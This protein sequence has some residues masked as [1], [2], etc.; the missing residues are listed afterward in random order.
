ME[1]LDLRIGIVA[2]LVFTGGMFAILRREGRHHLRLADEN[3]AAFADRIAGNSRD[4]AAL[5]EELG[6]L[7]SR[8]RYFEVKD[9]EDEE[10]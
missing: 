6:R 7:E 3:N 9:F 5:R 2:S 10:D 8:I 4:I 1:N